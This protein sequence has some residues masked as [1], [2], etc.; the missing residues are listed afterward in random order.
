MV[1]VLAI[2]YVSTIRHNISHA[3]E[4]NVEDSTQL[5]YGQI[6]FIWTLDILRELMTLQE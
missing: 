3:V 6:K 4:Q 1:F 2:L 5:M